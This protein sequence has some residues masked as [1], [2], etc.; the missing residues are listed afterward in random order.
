MWVTHTHHTHILLVARE[1]TNV[2]NIIDVN[3]SAIE[4]QLGMKAM[5][6]L[7]ST[8]SKLSGTGYGSYKLLA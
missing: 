6:M 7:I 5:I 4:V 2:S 3:A 1:S 8:C